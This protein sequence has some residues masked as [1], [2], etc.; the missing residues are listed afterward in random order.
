MVTHMVMD[1]FLL[2][3]TSFGLAVY[4]IGSRTPKIIQGHVPDLK[5]KKSLR[6]LSFFG[7]C[8]LWFSRWFQVSLVL[9]LIDWLTEFCTI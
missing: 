2:H 1:E 8:M 3:A 5:L 7:C 9:G 4:L 6:Y